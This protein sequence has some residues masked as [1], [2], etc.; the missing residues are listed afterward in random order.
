MFLWLTNCPWVNK[1]YLSILKHFFLSKI[2]RMR[3]PYALYGQPW[4]NVKI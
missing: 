1:D 2:A 3:T 4:E